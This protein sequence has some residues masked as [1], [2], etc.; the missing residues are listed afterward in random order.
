[1]PPTTAP[2]PSIAD[3]RRPHGPSGATLL[4]P[5]PGAPLARWQRTLPDALA[6]AAQ[7]IVAGP[8]LAVRAV[9]DVD[10]IEPVVDAGLERAGIEPGHRALLVADIALLG[11][12]LATEADCAAVAVRVEHDP[13][14]RCPVFHQDTILMRL[15]CTYAG[16]GTEWLPERLL[17]RREL[18]LRGRSPAEA[19][20][21]IALGEPCRAAPGEVLVAYGRHHGSG[22]DGPVHRSPP[23]DA[24]PRLVL[25]IDP[26]PGSS[27]T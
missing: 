8:T 9:A 19:N 11:R 6:A 22:G 25:A 1:M 20:S 3:L 7:E 12:L 5:H 17:D 10:D 23:A 21:A 14:G 4:E 27:S 16:P 2:T 13:S 24:G 15:L 26:E 18:G